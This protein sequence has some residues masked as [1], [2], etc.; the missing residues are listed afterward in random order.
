M[1]LIIGY[2]GLVGQSILKSRKFDHY[3]NSKNIDTFIDIAKDGD[4]LFLCRLPAENG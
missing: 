4:D 3:F 1:K 2:N